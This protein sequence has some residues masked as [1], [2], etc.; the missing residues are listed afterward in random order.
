MIG[1]DCPVCTSADP[2]DERLRASVLVRS[3]E[4]TWVIDTGP[5]FRRQ[6]LREK[7]RHLDAVF[8]SHSHTDHVMGFDDLR[9][10]CDPVPLPVY[11]TP[12]TMADLRRVFSFAFDGLHRY[13]GYVIPDPRELLGPVE[14]DGTRIAPL[15]LPHGRASCTGYLFSQNDKPL[16]AYLSDC[17]DVPLDVVDQVKGVA[18]LVLDALREAP[19]PTHMHVAQAIRI[20]GQIGPGKTFFTHM[21]HEVMHAELSSRLPDGIAL[22]YDG[23]RISI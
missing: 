9:R 22:A 11:A 16:F 1:C 14:L 21:G 6:C 4:Q 12:D 10:F 23:L 15:E 20:A 8:Y 3:P 2:H 5:D 13:P 18:V 19:H 7:V 17:H